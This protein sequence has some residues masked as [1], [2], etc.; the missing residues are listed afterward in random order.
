MLP[1]GSPAPE[2]TPDP[3]IFVGSDIITTSAGAIT[4]PGGLAKDSP[5]V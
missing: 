5:Q 4:A 3:L 2:L 1:N